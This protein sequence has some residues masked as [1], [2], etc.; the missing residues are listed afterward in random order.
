M[1]PMIPVNPPRT[2]VVLVESTQRP[3]PRPARVAFG[4]VLAAGA[5]GIAQGAQ[6][7]VSA[8]P[9]SAVTA[10]AVRGGG[11][12]SSAS[13]L[14]LSPTSGTTTAEGP[15]GAGGSPFSSV[16]IPLASSTGTSTSS[17]PLGG[18]SLGGAASSGDPT[19]T[20]EASLQQSANLNLYYLQ[21]QEQEDSQN[22]AFTAQSNILKTE[23]DG[24]KNAIGNIHS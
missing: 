19:S 18:L 24:C 7:A 20:I 12:T 3:T 16:G 21:L 1:D 22:R 4:D 14:A 23:H 8:L 13:I 5:S 11:S 2:D 6:L 10:A 17:S 15:G 9:G